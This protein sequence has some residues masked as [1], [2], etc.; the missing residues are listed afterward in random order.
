MITRL[1]ETTQSRCGFLP[2]NIFPNVM[3][4]MCIWG[5]GSCV[6]T[7]SS[8]LPPLTALSSNYRHNGG[9]RALPFWL[10]IYKVTNYCNSS[11]CSTTT[12]KSKDRRRRAASAELSKQPY[13]CMCPVY[14]SYGPA[15]AWIWESLPRLCVTRA[16]SRPSSRV[17]HKYTTINSAKPLTLLPSLKS[18]P[19]IYLITSYNNFVY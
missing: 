13:S 19:V 11:R 12:G 6:T 3:L 18:L 8:T 1:Q 9:T 7:G 16:R 15:Q 17:T 14:C 4:K 5:L 10:S 2:C